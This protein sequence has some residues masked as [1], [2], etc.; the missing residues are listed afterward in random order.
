MGRASWALPVSADMAGCPKSA[1]LL[2]TLTAYR[3]GFL[4]RVAESEEV[5]VELAVSLRPVLP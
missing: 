4:D 5:L 1:F 2:A 3:S